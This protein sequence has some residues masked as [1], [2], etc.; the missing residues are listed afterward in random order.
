MYLGQVRD[1]GRSFA[2][3]LNHVST[4]V[5]PIAPAT[6]DLGLDLKLP[7]RGRLRRRAWGDDANC[8][9]RHAA[10]RLNDHICAGSARFSKFF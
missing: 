3:A 7:C 4:A 2:A 8:A 6:Q 9:A 1:A 10:E 5:T